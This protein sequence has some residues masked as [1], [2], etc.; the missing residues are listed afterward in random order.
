VAQIR[1]AGDLKQ[2]LSDEDAARIVFYHFR[3]DQFALVAD[4]FGWGK[5]RARDWIRER[6]ELALLADAPP[7]PGDR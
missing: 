2:E 7:L 1:E 6:V 4:G 3:F 5:D